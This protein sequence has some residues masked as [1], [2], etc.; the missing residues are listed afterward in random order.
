[1]G[2][3]APHPA[4]A[5]AQ[6]CSEETRFRKLYGAAGVQE[7]GHSGLAMRISMGRSPEPRL[8]GPTCPTTQSSALT[9]VPCFLSCWYAATRGPS[10]R[11][12]INGHRKPCR[13]SYV[14][15]DETGQGVV[16][17]GWLCKDHLWPSNST[18]GE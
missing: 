7:A 17:T 10:E 8:R 18:H 11:A 3:N 13:P 12:D 14:Q 1:M 6:G 16:D 9:S 5:S 2:L 4:R 15:A